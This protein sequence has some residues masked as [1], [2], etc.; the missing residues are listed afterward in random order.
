MA[1]KGKK[2]WKDL[3]SG[4]RAGVIGLGAVQVGL[5]AAA[6]RDLAGRSAAQV[7]GNKSV[8]AAVIGINFIGP[9][10]YFVRGRR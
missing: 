1:G 6:W 4:Q 2:R 5:A 3:S 9:I 10:L 8:W 7:R